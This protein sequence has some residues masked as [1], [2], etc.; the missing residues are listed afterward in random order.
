MKTNFW[1]TLR[2]FSHGARMYLI[3]SA[4]IGLTYFG[5]VSVLL[6]LYLL[7]LG[8]DTQ[9]IGLANGGTSLAFAV[10]S[11]PAGAIGNRLGYTRAVM[12]GILCLALGTVLLPLSEYLP[13]L[14]QDTGIVFSRILNGAGFALY[15][16]NAQPYLVA[17]T[18]LEDRNL[19][20]ALQVAL[21][22]A[23]GFLGNVIA[24]LLPELLAV[25]LGVSID[26]PLPFRFPLY[27]SAA[28]LLPALLALW[29]TDE[30][31]TRPV[32]VGQRATATE[33]FAKSAAPHLLIACLAF[34]ALFRM[35]GEGAARSFF[36]VY[37]DT[38]LNV[39][40]AR[41]GLLYAIGQI[42]A[43]PTA[44]L[45]PLLVRRWGKVSTA[46]GGTLGIA[47]SM[48]LMALVPHWAAVGAGFTGVIGMLSITR[49][50]T[51]V[52]QMEIVVPEWRGLMS[53][54]VS[55]AMGIGFSSMAL[56]GGYIIP[57]LGYRGLFLIGSAMVATSALLFWFF[58]R[59]PRGEF[60][61]QPVLE[62]YRDAT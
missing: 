58:F 34:T 32:A 6:N 59:V 56:G 21:P 9:F 50:V 54:V 45:A 4:L 55:M 53:G 16:V 60:A 5:F 1:Q 37:L 11:I 22:P 3:V 43:G 19:V 40:T 44:L 46:V 10:S 23:A 35:A 47:T 18:T 24:G 62:P 7:R 48:V 25:W 38:D 41:I 29:T 28:L 51:N 26:S 15:L 36:N 14:W 27:L 61:R 39:S 17:A 57:I 52:Y 33:S 13:A 2:H 49:A 8:Y 20:F 42:I 12:L 31:Q 30:L